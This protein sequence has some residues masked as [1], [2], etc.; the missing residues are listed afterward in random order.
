MPKVQ[1]LATL[2]GYDSF[3][4]FLL[5]GVLRCFKKHIKVFNHHTTIYQSFLLLYSSDLSFYYQERSN[6][7]TK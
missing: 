1:L 6:E 7:A 2:V 5:M 4:P 3:T